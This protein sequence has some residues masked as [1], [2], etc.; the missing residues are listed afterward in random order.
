VQGTIEMI[1]KKFLQENPTDWD[2]MLPYLSFALRNVRHAATVARLTERLEATLKLVRSNIAHAQAQTKR[3]YDKASTERVLTPGELALVLLP[4]SSK[5]MFSVWRG[6]FKVSRKLENNNYELII[7]RRKAIFHIN[8]LRRYY[9]RDG[10][11]SWMVLENDLDSDEAIVQAK[12][13]TDD[14]KQQITTDEKQ[15]KI[16]HQLTDEQR[17]QFEKMLSE[18]P[19]VFND[20]MG[21]ADIITHKI[22]VTD[23]SPCYTPPYRIPEPLREPVEREL[24]SMLRNGIIKRDDHSNWNSPLI[25]IKKPDEGLRLVNSFVALNE[26]TITEPYLMTNL[27]ELLSR[28]A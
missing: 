11:V 6:P 24:M 1:L 26:R 22:Q 28:A 8:S 19:D 23:E 12:L 21:K 18:F 25:V 15:F 20:K 7:G 27:N 9:E 3:Q 4:T 16:S 13:Y 17:A 10:K 5:K 14:A 2:K